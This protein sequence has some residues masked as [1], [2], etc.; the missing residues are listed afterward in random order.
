MKI[1]CNRILVIFISKKFV[2]LEIK[3]LVNGGKNEVNL[4]DS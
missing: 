2:K 4:A 1:T 3:F